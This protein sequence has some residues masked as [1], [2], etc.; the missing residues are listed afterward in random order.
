MAQYVLVESRDPFESRDVSYFY[1][2]AADLAGKGD[3]VTVF[4]VQN[5]ALASRKAA[6][7]NPL[8]ALLKSKAQVL[9]DSFSLKERGIGDAER[10]PSVKPAD[11]G[12]LL[13]KIM[14][15]KGTKVL[16]H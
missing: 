14:A 8:G 1:N 6:K 3:Q 5:G 16:W 2:V 10:H 12:D 7:G 9:V 13:D 15:Q 11:I 4:L